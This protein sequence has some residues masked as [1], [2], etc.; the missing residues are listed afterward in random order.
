MLHST[1]QDLVRSTLSL[2]WT[3]PVCC[4]IKCDIPQRNFHVSLYPLQM[5]KESI[6]RLLVS[7]SLYRGLLRWPNIVQAD[8]LTVFIKLHWWEPVNKI[9]FQV[10]L[11]IVIQYVCIMCNHKALYTLFHR[12]TVNAHPTHTQTT[13]QHW[14]QIGCALHSP[15]LSPS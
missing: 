11:S 15:F 10:L 6:C 14:V 7:K 8:L 5:H 3:Q 1:G 12:A 2:V 4:T 13:I 9:Y